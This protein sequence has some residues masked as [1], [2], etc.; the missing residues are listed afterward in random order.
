MQF[1]KNAKQ[2][3][4]NK[5]IALSFPIWLVVLCLKLTKFLGG[6]AAPYSPTTVGP[7]AL[8]Q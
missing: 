5:V 8:Q 4:G 6:R 1:K 7:G 3:A 2:H